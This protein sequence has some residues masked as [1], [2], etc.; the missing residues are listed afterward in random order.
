SIE[1]DR[2]DKLPGGVFTK[3][4]VRQYARALGLDEEEIA[5]ELQRV[6]Q[7]REEP[8][9]GMP[10]APEHEIRM[11]KV[12]Q[13][14]GAG[15]RLRP[16]SSLPALA[17]V[18]VVM[19]ICS[20]VYTWW[21]TS[22]TKPAAKV[23]SSPVA[24]TSP[25]PAA[26]PVSTPAPATGQSPAAQTTPVAAPVTAALAKTDLSADRTALPGPAEVVGDPAGE[27]HVALK[28]EAPT[29]VAITLDGKR[30]YAGTLQP[31][32]SKVLNATGSVRVLVG[33]AGG[34]AVTYNG[35]PVGPL[36]PS[37]Q[38]RIL[39]VTPQQGAQILP[40][41]PAAPMADTL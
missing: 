3:S 6:L 27:V 28:A 29:W 41:K 26:I 15:K 10:Q 24:Q 12:A 4:F 37:G 8:A 1:A 36:G 23:S 13:W 11:P 20:G 14:E 7:E 16:S 32:E 17:G 21:Q 2:F 25:A 19:L 31:N 18:V 38:V 40:P 9:P 22:K 5:A 34:L 35:Q 39:Q 33:N 30:V